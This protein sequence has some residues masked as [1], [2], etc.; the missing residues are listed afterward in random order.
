MNTLINDLRQAIRSAMKTP[1]LSIIALVTVALGIGA[2]AAIFSLLDASI[3]RPP[4]KDPASLTMVLNRLPNM[5]AGPVSLPDFIEWRK[6]NEVFASLAA[7][8]D[9]G[10]SLTGRSEPRRISGALVSEGFFD[11][12]RTIPQRGRGFSY[13]DHKE[14]AAPV[15]LISD[16]LWRGEFHGTSRIT[17]EPILLDGVAC[18]II[19]VLPADT[20]AL[21][22]PGKTDVWMPLEPR[23]PYK[24]RGTNY[25]NIVGRLRP[26][27]TL[28]R[29]QADID[30]IQSR[31][32]AEFPENR[33]GATVQPLMSILFGDTRPVLLVLIA[34][35]GVIVLI[36][37]A[38]LANL[39]LARGSSR[40]KE[41][42][43]RQAL[44]ADRGRLIRQLMTES[45]FMAAAGGALGFLAAPLAANGLIAAGPEGLRLPEKIDPDWRIAGFT[46]VLIL[47]VA[48]I[49]GILPA[50]RG[51]RTEL[52]QALRVNTQQLNDAA[53][54]LAGR[55]RFVVAEIALA[56]V[57]MTAA[58][59][60]AGSL[61]RL[62]QQ[63]P[64]FDARNLL[65]MDIPLTGHRYP[66]EDQ[67]AEFFRS[68]LRKIRLIP[69]VINAGAISSLPVG[70]S[71]AT[72]DFFIEG[73]PRPAPDEKA[74]A[75]KEVV[76]PGYFEAM[77]IPLIAG[78]FFSEQDGRN[79]P[80]AVIIS[81][82]M[83]RQFWPGQNPLGHRMH[84]GFGK[85]GELQKI[86]GVVGDVKTDGLGAPVP[87]AIYVCSEQY[88]SGV[89][90][91]VIRTGV[92]PSAMV[93]AARSAVF[94]ID[95][96]Q[97]VSGIAAMDRILYHSLSRPRSLAWLLSAFAA[98]ALLLAGIG[99]YGVIA[100]SVTQKTAEIGMRIALG[101]S[102]RDILQLVLGSGLKLLVAGLGIGAIASAGSMQLL[103][104]QLFGMNTVDPFALF[105]VAA[106][107][108]VVSMMACYVPARRAA[109]VDPM[110]ALRN[111]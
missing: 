108:A 22:Y 46:L 18:E 56:A 95:K 75:I 4:F 50:I 80:K 3:L 53:G 47:V 24:S 25:L 91:V 37:C 96:E 109:S 67:Q 82:R 8:F 58:F 51:A 23:A 40:A 30:T 90:A 13:G 78:R 79:A 38:N 106:V 69:G 16:N 99:I 43:L 89:M 55:H 1:V 39:L 84:L 64:G 57:L 5:P 49:S 14:G 54:R 86:I 20:P 93:S 42:A 21:S 66:S 71:S 105:S 104:S 100:Y 81:Q 32:N 31:I 60:T 6:Q 97:P 41:F 83:A 107:L 2:N 65:T 74:F 62:V 98:I 59:L 61:W 7:Y 87:L 88:P 10:M 28:N 102:R 26:G 19:G 17:G 63:N 70:T 76:T 111:E 27:I 35:A 11:V 77:K 85:A 101:A 48:V 94:S 68:L 36:A 45:L 73:R 9:G 52:S 92:T 110:R 72:G 44:G 29:A 34:A 12:F 33:H 103:R 15:C